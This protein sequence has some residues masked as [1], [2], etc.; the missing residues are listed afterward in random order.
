MKN[1]VIVL[2]FGALLLLFTPALQAQ[3]PDFIFSSHTCFPP[4]CA[5]EWGPAF[6]GVAKAS[7]DGVCTGGAIGGIGADVVATIGINPETGEVQACQ[8]MYYARAS[9]EIVRTERL[10]DFCYTYLLEEVREMGAILDIAR[11]PVWH[12]EH[13]AGC[14]G[15][16]SDFT[17]FG[18]RPC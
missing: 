4:S 5:D 7:F 1:L 8:S 18:T 12:K 16:Y 10:D 3:T 6:T 14:D 15:G 9:F 2:G 13:Y 17:S 11:F